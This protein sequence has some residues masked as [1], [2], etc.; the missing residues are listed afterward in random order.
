MKF[1]IYFNRKSLDQK[2]EVAK[3]KAYGDALIC[4]RALN[5]AAHTEGITYTVERLKRSK[6]SKS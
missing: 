5:E 4:S 3:V 1:I 2:I 6:K